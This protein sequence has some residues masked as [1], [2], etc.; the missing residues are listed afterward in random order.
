MIGAG[1]RFCWVAPIWLLVSRRVLDTLGSRQTQ[2]FFEVLPSEP[3]QKGTP[4]SLQMVICSPSALLPLSLSRLIFILPSTLYLSLFYVRLEG[5]FS[6]LLDLPQVDTFKV[7][8]PF[9][10]GVQL[11]F[12]LSLLELFLLY[13]CFTWGSPG[14]QRCLLFGSLQH[15]YLRSSLQ[16]LQSP[17]LPVQ[18]LSLPTNLPPPADLPLTLVWEPFPPSLSALLPPLLCLLLFLF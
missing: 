12:Q 9:H 17:F 8:L 7:H 6:A 18:L 5:S 15:V 4:H 13:L 2:H 16:P 10:F 1:T 14:H 3:S 11:R